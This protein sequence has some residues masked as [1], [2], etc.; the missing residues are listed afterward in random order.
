[1]ALHMPSLSELRNS[2]VEIFK[3]H[4]RVLIMQGVVLLCFVLLS[5]RLFYLQVIRHEDLLEQAENNRTAVLP[6]VPNRGTILDRNG[7]V[8]ANNYSAYTLE[9]APSRVKN[10]DATIDGLSE[11]IDISSR[12]KRRFKRVREESK[13]FDSLPIRSRLTDEEVARFSAQQF[14]F[15]GVE[16]K[17]RLFRNYPFGHLASHVVGYIGRINQKEKEQ[18]EESDEEGNYRGTQYIGKLGVEQRYERELHGITGVQEVETSAGGRAVRRLATRPATPGQNVVLSLDI[19]LQKMVED[20]FGDR[21][22]ALVAV[23]PRTGEILAFVSKPTFDPNLFVDGI[24]SESWKKLSESI[25][26][27]LLNRATRGTYPPGSTYKPF[28]AL[29]ALETGKRSASEIIIDSGSWAYGGHTFRS[30]G[31]SGLGAV[32][33]VRSIV[34]SSNVY[35]YSLAN[36]Q[37]NSFTAIPALLLWLFVGIFLPLCAGQGAAQFAG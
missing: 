35:Y 33:M 21:R 12:D 14:R 18:I 2:Q 37:R 24:D 19:K 27:P 5:I 25:D 23:D 7:V 13:N 17:A 16:I 20:L 15:P 4:N 28:M 11:I 32:D 22:G 1:M 26:K 6:T 31:D 9:I 36:A 34:L 3:F 30:H 29:A 8:L 10:L